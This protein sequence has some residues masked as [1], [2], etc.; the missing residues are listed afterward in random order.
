MDEVNNMVTYK[1]VVHHT[2]GMHYKEDIVVV[3]VVVTNNTVAMLVAKNIFE[4]L[5]EEFV[6]LASV[7]VGP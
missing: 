2:A 5:E 7:V 1:F 3:V 6:A 4:A